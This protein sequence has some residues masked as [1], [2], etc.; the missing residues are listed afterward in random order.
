MIS[1]LWQKGQ[2]RGCDINDS[3]ENLLLGTKKPPARCAGAWMSELL[4]LALVS[5]MWLKFF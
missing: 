3:N 4:E 1:A 5:D 2:M